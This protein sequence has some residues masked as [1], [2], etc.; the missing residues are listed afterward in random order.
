M[1]EEN[2][3]AECSDGRMSWEMSRGCAGPVQES[4]RA[5]VMIRT[6][7]VNTQTHTQSDIVT[8]RQPLCSVQL[9][10]LK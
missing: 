2:Y 1:F 6:T 7:L 8:D 9:A 4:L 10:E 5:A 3:P